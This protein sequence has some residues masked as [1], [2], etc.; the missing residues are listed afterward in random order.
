MNAPAPA[1]AAPATGST[2]GAA[3]KAATTPAVSTPTKDTANGPQT[4]SGGSGGAV[5]GEDGKF[6]SASGAAATPED[7]DPEIDFGD[8]KLKRS[9]A[10]REIERAR[11]A[12]KLLTEAEK[13]IK[14]AEAIE[15]THAERRSK[16]D[17]ASI[18]EEL[19]LTPEEERAFLS[20]RM[21]SK[22]I[23]PEQMSPEQR[24]VAELEAWKAQREASDKKTAEETA[25]KQKKALTDE[26]SK[27]LHADLIAAA[28]AGKLPKSRRAIQRIMD[29]A[30][31]FD[32]R[33]MEL[34]L[35]QLAALV[36][37]EVAQDVVDF[38]NTT[39]LDERRSLMGPE[40]FRE[41]EKKWLAHFNAK[42]KSTTT[43]Q[44]V[45]APPQRPSDGASKRETF[46]PQEFLARI[47]GR[48]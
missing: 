26:E 25:A 32:S 29:K 2:N 15:K 27:R 4:S 34:P 22:H 11:S 41:E 12:S 24:K 18:I 48:K 43:S 13:R 23:A 9:A 30:V 7:D 16:K 37:D 8:V 6:K 38:T 17:L 36:R 35:E 47:N 28:E 1:P 3:P 19:G 31:A 5:R 42:L 33:G 21:Y 45:R 39:G 44:P 10:K 40:K 20:E 46:T 14:A